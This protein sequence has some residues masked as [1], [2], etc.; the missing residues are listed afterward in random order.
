MY[1]STRTHTRTHTH[2]HTH[3]YAHANTNTYTRTH[4]PDIQGH[5]WRSSSTHGS[6]R[7]HT[8]THCSTLHY[9]ATTATHGNKLQHT[10]THMHHAAH[11]TYEDPC[12]ACWSL[13]RLA[14]LKSTYHPLHLLPSQRNHQRQEQKSI[15]DGKR[16]SDTA[17]KRCE[18][19]CCVQVSYGVA[20]GWLR[21][22]GSF[23]LEVSLAEYS[24]FYRALLQTRPII[25]RSLLIVATPYLL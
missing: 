4:T 3:T 10:A 8:A 5:A 2:T 7:Q 11:L 12:V 15:D 17:P 21:L 25:L 9:T 22:V 24:L 18:A 16:R 20:M 14:A 23:K 1:T 19:V 13:L 6:T